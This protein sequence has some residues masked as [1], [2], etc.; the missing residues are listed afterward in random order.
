[1][2]IKLDLASGYRASSVTAVWWGDKRGKLARA[3]QCEAHT[4]QRGRKLREG[5]QASSS[6]QSANYGNFGFWKWRVYLS[7]CYGRMARQ[8]QLREE[9]F[10]FGSGVKKRESAIMAGM[11]G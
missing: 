5:G 7:S 11:T 4:G 2:R 9:R 3:L 6:Q 8:K 10:Y 1:M